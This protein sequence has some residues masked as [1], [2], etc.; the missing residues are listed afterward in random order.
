MNAF[1]MQAA[2]R[3]KSSHYVQ[4]DLCIIGKVKLDTVKKIFIISSISLF[5]ILS[6]GCYLNGVYPNSLIFKIAYPISSGIALIM[7]V[8]S[9]YVLAKAYDILPSCMYRNQ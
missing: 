9:V 7:L 2:D 3:V 5:I 6:V 8:D 1:Q 4:A